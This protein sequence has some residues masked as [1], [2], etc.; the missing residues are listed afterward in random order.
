[1]ATRRGSFDVED[2]LVNTL[3][4]CIGFSAW[5]VSARAGRLPARGLLFVLVVCGMAFAALCAAEVFNTLV[6]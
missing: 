5:R 6:F 2:I 1:M 3:G 4:F